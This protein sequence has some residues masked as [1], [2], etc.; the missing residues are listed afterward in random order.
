MVIAFNILILLTL[1]LIELII[2]KQ[3]WLFNFE[4]QKVKISAGV[5]KERLE[6][7]RKKIEQLNYDKDDLLCETC[8]EYLIY[9]KRP[10]ID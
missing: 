1:I 9:K 3:F 4:L 6:N 7:A 8:D 5:H 10:S 2:I